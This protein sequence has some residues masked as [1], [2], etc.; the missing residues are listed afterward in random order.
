M[1]FL[2]EN[3]KLF[4]LSQRWIPKEKKIMTTFLG[5]PYEETINEAASECRK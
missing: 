1:S 4:N 2:E 3:E 5:K